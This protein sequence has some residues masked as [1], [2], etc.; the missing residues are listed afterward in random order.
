MTQNE[1]NFIQEAV[2]SKCDALL[3]TIVNNANAQLKKEQTKQTTKK[4][5]NK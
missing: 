3:E 1:M 5:E 2:Y 4:G